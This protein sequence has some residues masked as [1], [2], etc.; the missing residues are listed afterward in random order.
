M[1]N[2]QSKIYFVRPD[3]N[4]PAPKRIHSSDA[5]SDLVCLMTS[6]IKPFETKII[7]TNMRIAIPHGFFGRVC[8]RSGLSSQGLL[9]H[10]GTIDSGY[11]GIVGV[12]ATNLTDK[13]MTL[14]SSSRIAQIIIL[15]ILEF[16]LEEVDEL[17]ERAR[18]DKGFGHSG[19]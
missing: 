9:V 17:P 12:I 14:E 4:L 10:P 6:V 2:N 11:T 19:M 18:G 7:G 5:G 8:G 16:D 13:D 3:K 15:P 1:S